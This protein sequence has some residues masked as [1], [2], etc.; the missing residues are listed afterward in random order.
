[1]ASPEECTCV[2]FGVLDL[3]FLGDDF[4]NYFRI[5]HSLVRQWIHVVVRLRGFLEVFHT[6]YVK[7]WITDLEVDS[8]L[9]ELLVFSAMLGATLDTWCFQS[10]WPLHMCS[11]WTR[12]FCLDP[13][14]PH[15]GGSAVAVPLQG[16]QHPCRCAET[17]SH[18][19]TSETI[20]ILLLQ[21]IDT[22]VD[23]GCASPASA[24]F[25]AGH[26]RSHACC[27]A[28]TGA[29]AGRDSAVVGHGPSS[30]PML[31]RCWQAPGHDTFSKIHAIRVTSWWE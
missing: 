15:N 8:R 9:S 27:C 28:T 25:D 29:L 3:D 31:H 2:A 6:F 17:A 13:E 10:S 12:L 20:E 11:S 26:C 24:C 1:M 16:R 23:V 21:Y 5:K 4:R 22:V 18:G 30:E 7:R 14:V 19:L